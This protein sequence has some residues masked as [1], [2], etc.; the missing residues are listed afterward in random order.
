M[1]RMAVTSST[2]QFGMSPLKLVAPLNIAVM[3]VTFSTFQF[4]MSPLKLVAP[5]NM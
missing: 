4:E 1:S 3:S 2:F 5:L